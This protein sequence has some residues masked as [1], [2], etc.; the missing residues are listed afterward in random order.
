[1]TW[2]ELVAMV[3]NKI[4]EEGLDP[5]TLELCHIEVW[6]HETNVSVSPAYGDAKIYCIRGV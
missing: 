1:M 6:N 3:E 2:T 5:E 4:K